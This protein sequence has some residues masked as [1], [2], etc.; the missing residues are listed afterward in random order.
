MSSSFEAVKAR[1]RLA[2]GMGVEGYAKHSMAELGPVA[3]R[4]IEIADPAWGASVIDLACGPGTVTLRVARRVGPGA[5]VMGV[6]LAAP[7]VAHAERRALAEGITNVTFV[8]GDVEVLE[9]VPDA[10]FDVALSNFGIVFA[11]DSERMVETVARVLRP[12][13]TLAFSTWIERGIALELNEFLAGILPPAPAGATARDSWGD[14]DVSGERLSPRF[15][16][17]H[18]T[19]IE[20]P[21]DYANVDEA[22]TRMRDGRPPFALAYGRLPAEQKQEIERNAR[23]LFRRHAGE[24]GRVRYVRHA[25]IVRGTRRP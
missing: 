10:S 12:G 1:H 23:E 9:G 19:E 21:C 18:W 25:G 17:L 14:P 8:E 15:D 6:D 5:Q 2:W 22:W 4:L 20:V 13:G 3:D 7:M 16:E 11:P 24:D